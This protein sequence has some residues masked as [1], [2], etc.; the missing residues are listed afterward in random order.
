MSKQ[1]PSVGRVVHYIPQADGKVG[2]ANEHAAIVTYVWTPEMVNL[3]VFNPNGVHYF[4]T[5]V[6][7]GN[8][9]GCWKWPEFIPPAKD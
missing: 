4:Q 8:G 6:E 3:A 1:V 9:P 7:H 5:S 2:D